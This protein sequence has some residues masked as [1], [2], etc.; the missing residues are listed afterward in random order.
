MVGDWVK[1][2]KSYIVWAAGDNARQQG[3]QTAGSGLDGGK[4]Q[5]LT[6]GCGDDDVNQ[7]PTPK[8]ACVCRSYK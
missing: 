5:R 1:R 4:E 3:T 2:A 6:V 8:P 7:R